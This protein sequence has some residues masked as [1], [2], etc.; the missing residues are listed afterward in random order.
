MDVPTKYIPIMALG[1]STEPHFFN[2]HI[3]MRE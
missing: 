3:F 2:Q 1:Y